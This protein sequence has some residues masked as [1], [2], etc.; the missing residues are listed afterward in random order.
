M[1]DRT[2]TLQ[3]RYNTAYPVELLYDQPKQG[4]SQYGKYNLYGLEYNGEQY[5]LFAEDALHEELKQ[6]KKGS[7]V[8]IERNQGSK[9]QLQWQVSPQ[10]GSPSHASTVET[11]D[12][13]TMEIYRS[14][15]L[16]IATM[17]IGQ[18]LKPWG[19]DELNEI[20]ERMQ[21]LLLIL[22]GEIHNELPF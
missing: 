1:S 9:G 5:G 13:R 15:S 11:I 14:L 16:K 17:S 8:V 19:Q 21:K 18:S 6:F 10:N 2:P 12:K 3:I 7:H 20:Q 22:M 4:E